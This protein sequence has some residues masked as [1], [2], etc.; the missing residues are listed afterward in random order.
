MFSVIASVCPHVSFVR[1][2]RVRSPVWTALRRPGPGLNDLP[3]SGAAPAKDVGGAL[4]LEEGDRC[5]IDPLCLGRGRPLVIR[6]LRI[7][8]L[9]SVAGTAPR[10]A[11]HRSARLTRP[12]GDPPAGTQPRTRLPEGRSTRD[13]PLTCPVT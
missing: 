7:E 9:R 1:S 5:H 2:D 13:A 4:V 12:A 6:L 3:T 8:M 10:S 11:C